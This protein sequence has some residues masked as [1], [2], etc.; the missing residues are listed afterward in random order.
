MSNNKRELKNLAEGLYLY[1][2]MSQKD[3]AAMLN[4]TEKTITDWKQEGEWEEIKA[5]Y[6]ITRD[7]IIANYYRQTFE[8]QEKARDEKRTLT[9][10]ETDQL[11]KIANCIEKL[12]KSITMHDRVQ[13]FMDFNNWL[14]TIDTELAKTLSL[15]Q[16]SYLKFLV[17][18]RGK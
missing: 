17:K 15:K 1:S 8:I 18:L 7:K 13:V 2:D 10:G 4:V 12:D 9:S 16:Q 14:V 11:V 3:I 5:A 6:G